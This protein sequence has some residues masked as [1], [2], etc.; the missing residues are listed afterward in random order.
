MVLVFIPLLFLFSSSI[1]AAYK[2]HANVVMR[3]IWFIQF[4]LVC[5]THFIATGFI[6]SPKRCNALLA[7]SDTANC[8]CGEYCVLQLA[9]GHNEI[10]DNPNKRTD[11]REIENGQAQRDA[12]NN[13]Q[14]IDEHD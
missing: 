2:E 13:K 6:F 8:M 7:N 14:K 9:Y 4:T 5:F 11:N 10:A 12:N 1:Q 3:I